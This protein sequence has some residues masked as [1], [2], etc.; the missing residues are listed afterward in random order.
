MMVDQKTYRKKSIS[1]DWFV[2]G[3]LARLGDMFDQ[4]TGRGWKPS[5]SLA[6]S[7]VI[8]RLKAL[9][10]AEAREQ[11]GRTYVP[12]LV[13]LKMQWDKFSLD[14]EEAV[15][16]LETEL[17]T[18]L[19]DHINDRRY[20][21]NGPILLQV[22]P[23][24]FTDGV[25]LSAAFEKVEEEREATMDVNLP[26]SN[27]ESGVAAGDGPVRRS[28]SIEF[29]WKIAGKD[30]ARSVEVTS[31]DRVTVGRTQENVVAL[32]G[33]SVSKLHAVLLYAADGSIQLSD[34][35]S[36]NGTFVNGQRISYGKA[37]TV[38]PGDL[39]MFG[40]I[41]VLISVKQ[42]VVETAVIDMG[43]TETYTVGEFEF[44]SKNTDQA[45]QAAPSS[46]EQT[47]KAAANGESEMEAEPRP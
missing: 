38:S 24:Y 35:G 2:R 6:T 8:E 11:N 17:L 13:K 36:T 37:T 45:M 22:K 30:A 5:S 19:V 7:E 29:R 10:D 47:A 3:A 46:G 21:T 26:K 9:M 41:E 4:F 33:P 27:S 1:A 31:G 43:A 20:Y 16:M 12:H 39:L 40:S 15:K 28:A 34:T 14:S 32:D 44:A 25:K 18:A 42:A 23:D